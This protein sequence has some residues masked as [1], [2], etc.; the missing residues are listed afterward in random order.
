M[1]ALDGEGR[2]PVGGC[3]GRGKQQGEAHSSRPHHSLP[4]MA[5]FQL[6]SVLHAAT[7]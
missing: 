3:L 6:V 4:G 5:H 2:P 7:L 1:D